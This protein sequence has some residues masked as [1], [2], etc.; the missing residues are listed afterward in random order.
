MS[1]K[2]KKQRMTIRVH[3]EIHETVKELYKQS[4]CTTMSQFYE[5]AI[6]FYCD[7]LTA[8]NPDEYLP[9]AFFRSMDEIIDER[10]DNF[11]KSIFPMKVETAMLQNLIAIFIAL[12]RSRSRECAENAWM[13]S[14][15]SRER[16]KLK[17]DKYVKLRQTSGSF[18]AS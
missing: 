9:K 10:D 2:E 15:V 7:Y 11:E 17:T 13:K 12:I 4:G 5:K 16:L 3:P 14:S 1:E 8:E 6:R 18:T